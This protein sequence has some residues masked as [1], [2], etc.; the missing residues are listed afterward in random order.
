MTVNSISAFRPDGVHEHM[1]FYSLVPER[2]S[3]F[4]QSE[5]ESYGIEVDSAPIS[6]SR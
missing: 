3:A 2:R 1:H 6:A 4:A 5:V